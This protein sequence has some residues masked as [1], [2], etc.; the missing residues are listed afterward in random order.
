MMHLMN[1]PI[2][3][4]KKKTQVIN[5]KCMVLFGERLSRWS[6]SPYRRCDWFFWSKSPAFSVIDSLSDCVTTRENPSIRTRLLS[7]GTNTSTGLHFKEQ[8]SR[9]ST[10]P[11]TRWCKMFRQRI[12]CRIKGICACDLLLSTMTAWRKPRGDNSARAACFCRLF[13][14]SS[15]VCQLF[16]FKAIVKM[17]LFFRK[18][19]KFEVPFT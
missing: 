9:L 18:C 15:G 19:V 11:S 1:H 14:R 13:L 6:K 3:W 8:T 4:R 7:S 2:L 16:F 10:A 12:C 5:K 17:E